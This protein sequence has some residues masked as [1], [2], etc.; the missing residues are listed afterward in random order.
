MPAEVRTIVVK[1]VRLKLNSIPDSFYT[2]NFAL[3]LGRKFEFQ[4]QQT[5]GQSKQCQDKSFLF[6]ISKVNDF[7]WNIE[8][9]NSFE[10]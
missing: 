2:S 1:N 10:N 5:R 8:D 9:T 6:D 3:D 7:K 4:I